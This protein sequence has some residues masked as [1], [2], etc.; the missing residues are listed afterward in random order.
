MTHLVP[1]ATLQAAIPDPFDDPVADLVRPAGDGAGAEPLLSLVGV[2]FDT[3]TM[4]RRGSR[5]APAGIRRTL[6]GLLAYHAGF[7]VDLAGSGG[8]ADFGDVDVVE[9]DVEA[10][11]SRISDVTHALAGEG[12]PLAVLGGDHGLTFPALRGALRA[13]RGT[14]ALVSLD[15][16]YDVRP[17]H[18]GQP[19]SG[20]PFRWA[21]ERLDGRV[22][23]SA[24]TQIGMAGWENSGRAAAYLA[25][26]G[27]QVFPARHVHRHGLDDVLEETLRRADQADGLWL[28]LDID[29][30]DVAYAPGTN[31][32]TV[33]GLTSHQLLEVVWTLARHERLIG[34]DVVEVSPP[35]DVA[36]ATQLLAAHLL[37]TALAARLA[38]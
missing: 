19:A 18:R 8:I 38:G 34:L 11:W 21:L 35:Y 27:V 5:H 1:A 28:T 20:V 13:H 10:T 6:A 24:C 30:A 16:H 7:G 17:S 29:A 23:P 2:P 31:A 12:R 4:G 36:D 3:T 33:G 32:P 26:Q 25:E 14:V 15:A 22:P 37:L 9:T